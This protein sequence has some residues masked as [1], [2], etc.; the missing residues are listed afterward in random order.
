MRRILTSVGIVIMGLTLTVGCRSMTGQSLG[1]NIDNKTTTA[2]VKTQLTAERLQNL[3]WVDVD[4]NAGTVY[5]SGT[6]STEAQ[7]QRAE[8]IARNVDGVKKVVNN[9]QVKPAAATASTSQAS[10]ST[11]AASPSASAATDGAMHR[12]TATGEVVSID[13][14]MGH[15]TIQSNN[16]QV[17]LNVPE[18][19]LQDIKVGDRVAVDFGIRPL[20]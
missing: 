7:K 12:Y 11:A 15:V 13:R 19:A 10:Q 14:S 16:G 20:R 9:I 6:A 18:S 4:T 5:L 3:G 8:E 1:T 17:M 2:A